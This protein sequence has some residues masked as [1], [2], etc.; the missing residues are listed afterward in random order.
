MS[1][2]RI[3]HFLKS[4]QTEAAKMLDRK[5]DHELLRMASD[6]TEADFLDTLAQGLPAGENLQLLS[7][8]MNQVRTSD[9]YNL[10]VEVHPRAGI[11]TRV[12]LLKQ[13]NKL[14]QFIPH[15]AE[16][17][18]LYTFS[19]LFARENENEG[20]VASPNSHGLVKR[21]SARTNLKEAEIL[22]FPDA[23]LVNI[24]QP[25]LISLLGDRGF[26]VTAGGLT[27]F[28]L[29]LTVGEKQNFSF[30]A[31]VDSQRP[32]QKQQVTYFF[33][34]ANLVEEQLAALRRAQPE[35]PLRLAERP[36]SYFYSLKQLVRDEQR[37]ALVRKRYEVI[38]QRQLQPDSF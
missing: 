26:E 5:S 9:D 37:V 23:E 25:K 20:G 14:D 19:V 12:H 36:M 38:F 34:R 32:H 29:P 18:L 31:V 6:I 2:E 24:T 35:L 21:L 11:V 4:I 33:R 16:P 22:A 7:Q 27:H 8:R 15:D 13:A 3:S 17:E 30:D 28:E 1:R 10:T